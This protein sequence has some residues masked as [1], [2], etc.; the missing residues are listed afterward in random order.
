MLPCHHRGQRPQRAWLLL[1]GGL[2]AG[3]SGAHESAQT[4]TAPAAATITPTA[5]VPAL[6]GASIDGLRKRLGAAQPLPVDFTDPLNQALTSGPTARP[7]SLAAFRTGGLTLIASYD[8]R[9]RQ[10]R[11]LVI[12]GR[13]EDSLMGRASLRANSLNY[14]IMPVFRVDKPSH[15]LGLRII[16]AK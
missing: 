10:V 2:A 8:A 9:T 15:L 14:L 7:D 12:L 5:N 6:L 4:A 11:D 3:C 13:H 1:A 16:K